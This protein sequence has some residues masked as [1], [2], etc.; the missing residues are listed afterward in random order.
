MLLIY[1]N[2][3][4]ERFQLELFFLFIL[5]PLSIERVMSEII[6]GHEKEKENKIGNIRIVNNK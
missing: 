1:G 2:R 4:L 5:L 6:R 3:W